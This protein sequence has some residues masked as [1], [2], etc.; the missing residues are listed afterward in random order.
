MVQQRSQR[1]S[2]DAAD[3][4]IKE[5]APRRQG[6]SPCD[7]VIRSRRW[8][9]GGGGFGDIFEERVESECV[10]GR[11]SAATRGVDGGS[12]RARETL[13]KAPL[14]I[15]TRSR[16]YQAIYKYDLC[17]VETRA[18]GFHGATCAA[19]VKEKRH[20]G[21]SARFAIGSRASV[22]QRLRINPAKV[23]APG[24]GMT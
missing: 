20:R 2:V 21:S 12:R 5:R 18:R 11:E 14:I 8:Q 13:V 15:A 7:P 22:Y 19:T 6:G 9:F 1:F 10:R 23:L 3:K 16:V 17:P 24:A 4:V